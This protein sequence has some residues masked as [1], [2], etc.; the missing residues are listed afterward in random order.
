MFG[1]ADGHSPATGI[2]VRG[3]SGGGCEE[4]VRHSP[5]SRMSASSPGCVPAKPRR[6]SQAQ[7]NPD[8]I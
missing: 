8:D 7:R 6:C 3:Q 2:E 5:G 4:M 1:C